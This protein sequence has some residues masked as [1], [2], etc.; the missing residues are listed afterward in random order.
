MIRVVLSFVL[1]TFTCSLEPTT[2]ST[3]KCHLDSPVYAHILC[4]LPHLAI[5]SITTS[6]SLFLPSLHHQ[7]FALYHHQFVHHSPP[8]IYTPQST[9]ITIFLPSNTTHHRSDDLTF[10]RS[11]LLPVLRDNARDTQLSYFVDRIIP[12]INN[13]STRCAWGWGRRCW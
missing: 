6:T 1:F 3:L 2:S 9:T 7:V 13:I 11:W 5:L 8:S 12:L 10:P 4:Y